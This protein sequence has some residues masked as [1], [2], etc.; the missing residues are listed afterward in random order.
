MHGESPLPLSCSPRPYAWSCEKHYSPSKVVD[1]T[2]QEDGTPWDSALPKKKS[3]GSNQR[4]VL[5]DQTSWQ[6]CLWSQ[7]W[8]TGAAAEIPCLRP[9]GG[10]HAC[11]RVSSALQSNMQFRATM[12][13]R[14]IN[15]SSRIRPIPCIHWTVKMCPWNAL[16]FQ[17]QNAELGII[18][19]VVGNYISR[20]NHVATIYISKYVRQVNYIHGGTAYIQAT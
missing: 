2:C 10:V 11:L 5:L 14:V 9:C 4:W 3:C 12:N 16:Q 7:R 15:P 20:A 13:S 19:P 1:K 6:A 8:P 17:F 18:R